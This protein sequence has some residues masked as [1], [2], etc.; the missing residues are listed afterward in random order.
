M[1]PDL[2]ELLDIATDFAPGDVHPNANGH[3]KIEAALYPFVIA[4]P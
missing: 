4:V 1:Q 2:Y 3:E